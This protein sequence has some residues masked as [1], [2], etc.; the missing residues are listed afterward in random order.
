MPH[1][2]SNHDLIQEFFACNPDEEEELIQL[3]NPGSLDIKLSKAQ[4]QRWQ[5]ND[6]DAF[7]RS[8]I[9]YELKKPFE[10]FDPFKVFQLML[11][12]A[13]LVSLIVGAIFLWP[14]AVG[15]AVALVLSVGLFVGINYGPAIWNWKDPLPLRGYFPGDMSG[16]ERIVAKKL[17]KLID[18]G[19]FTN[20]N[21]PD[22]S[23]SSDEDSLLY[24]NRL[25][26]N[27]LYSINQS[28]D[29]INR[30]ILKNSWQLTLK[31]KVQ[32]KDKRYIGLDDLDQDLGTNIHYHQGLTFFSAGVNETTELPFEVFKVITEK[33]F[34]LVGFK[35]KKNNSFS[36]LS[37]LAEKMVR[38]NSKPEEEASEENRHQI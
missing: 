24:A 23:S 37:L 9:K 14:F 27:V 10:D 36:I 34:E 22:F 8:M 2:K 7:V 4:R 1:P 25:S 32:Y 35:D 29:E 20:L 11:I 38:L 21:F 16:P 26:S 17:N 31:T 5:K 30:P 19:R 18:S 13:S 12:F 28:I 6:D 15:G 33:W 3:M